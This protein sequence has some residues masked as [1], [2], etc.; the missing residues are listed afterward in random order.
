[1]SEQPNPA[2]PS[3]DQTP[4]VKALLAEVEERVARKKAAGE[5]DAA[6]IRKVEE[7][8]V[9]LAPPLESRLQV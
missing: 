8:V 7:A 2:G 1:M 3:P 4:D 9:E 6:E 5:Y